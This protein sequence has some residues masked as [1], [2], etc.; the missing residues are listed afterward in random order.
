[1]KSANPLDL[2][3]I[4]Q[5]KKQRLTFYIM[6]RLKKFLN[7]RKHNK[8]N[9][10]LLQLMKKYIYFG[11]LQGKFRKSCKLSNTSKTNKELYPLLIYETPCLDAFTAQLVS[12]NCTCLNTE[13]ECFQPGKRKNLS[14]YLII[15][16]KSCL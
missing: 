8:I 9:Y 10:I 6:R 2:L 3:F 7:R 12:L 1:M 14:Q 15:L 5:V 11:I 13:T 4:F 16:K